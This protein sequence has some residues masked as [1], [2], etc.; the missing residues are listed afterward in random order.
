[1]SIP[2][3][4]TD[5][6]TN[7]AIRGRELTVYFTKSDESSA[8]PC[9]FCGAK[10]LVSAAVVDVT[11]IVDDKYTD[12]PKASPLF[13]ETQARLRERKLHGKPCCDDD[14]CQK[15]DAYELLGDFQFAQLAMDTVDI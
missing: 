12:V 1:M 2:N 8:K 10:S 14:V 3:P 11:S 9:R 4:K 6:S 13:N 7:M 5:H 15:K